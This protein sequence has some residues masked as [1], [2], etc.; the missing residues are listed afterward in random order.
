MFIA[1]SAEIQKWKKRQNKWNPVFVY[2]NSRSFLQL[3][4]NLKMCSL[5]LIHWLITMLIKFDK[6]LDQCGDCS[7]L[8][9]PM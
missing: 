1:H 5:D 3:T 8:Q 2:F 6:N 4:L 7:G 9:V